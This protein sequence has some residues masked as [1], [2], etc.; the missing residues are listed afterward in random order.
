MKLQ[1]YEEHGAVEE[2]SRR[3][4]TNRIGQETKIS[5]EKMQQKKE[6]KEKTKQR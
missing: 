6:M 2:C 4:T 5:A 3:R 1:S